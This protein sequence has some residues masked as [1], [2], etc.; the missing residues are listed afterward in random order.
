MTIRRPQATLPNLTYIEQDDRLYAETFKSIQT[1]LG[2]QAQQAGTNP[3]GA[4]LIPASPGKVQVQAAGGF[5]DVQIT[6]KSPILRAIQYYVE[7]DTDQ[8]FSNPRLVAWGPGRNP[9]FFL[10][11]GTYYVQVRSQYPQGGPPSA[12]TRWPNALTITGSVALT[13]FESQ[14]AGTGGGGAGLT[15]NRN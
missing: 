2:N 5:V 1:S 3:N 9:T 8:N 13:L 10:P 4:P 12:P 11:N 15:V 6:D 7:V 14:G